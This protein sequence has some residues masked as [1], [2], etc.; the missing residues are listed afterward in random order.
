MAAAVKK[1]QGLLFDIVQDIAAER[2]RPGDRLPSQAEMM[3]RYRAGATPLREAL[4]ML[5]LA[6]LVSV[7]P[8]PAA[9]PLIEEANAEH[10]AALVAPFLCVAGVTYGQLM[11]AWV[12]TEPLLAAAAA[13]NPDRAMVA[14]QLTG[15]AREEQSDEP[16]SPSHAID[17]HDA[18]ARAA[19]NPALGLVLQ[20]LSYVVADLYWA[21]TAVLPP[22]GQV[23][24]DHHDI[25]EAIL[26]GDAD[27]ARRSMEAHGRLMSE[28]ILASVGRTRDEPFAWSRRPAGS[29]P[30]RQRMRMRTKRS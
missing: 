14:A 8:G 24:H 28:R 16:V 9:G 2:L 5:E 4:R 27:R 19:G 23:R 30:Y 21:S 17:F 25:A 20:V 11:D 22:G 13:A 12:T 15:F 1:A 3:R 7:R 29:A 18:V 26:A 10:L 6:G